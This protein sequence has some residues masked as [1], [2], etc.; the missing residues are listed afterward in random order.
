MK[1]YIYIL[2]CILCLHVY[3]DAQMGQDPKAKLILDDIKSNYDSYDAVQMNFTLTLELPEQAPEVQQGIAIQ[4][5][6]KYKM[7]LDDQAIYSDG[8]AVW[9]HLKGNNE[10]QIN[11]IDMDDSAMM[12]PTDILKVYENGEYEYAITNTYKQNGVSISEIEFK[13]TDEDSEYSKMRLMVNGKNNDVKSFKIFSRDGSR[14]TLDIH[15]I[16]TDKVYPTDTFVFDAS[17][18]E[19]IYIEDLRID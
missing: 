16:V 1:K 13:P 4:S 14:Y 6:D 19:D 11:D 10:V 5:G 2:S 17:K 9:V 18:Y 12:S 7:E 3:A 15:E 8:T